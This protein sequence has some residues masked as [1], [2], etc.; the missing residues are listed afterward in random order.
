MSDVVLTEREGGLATVTVNRPE[1]LNALN[2]EVLERLA[3]TFA[4]LA[5]D[6][7]CRVII[8]RGAGDRAF[9]AGADIAAMATLAAEEARTF[10]ELGQ[11]VCNRIESVPQVVIAAVNGYALGGGLRDCAGV[12]L[13]GWQQNRPAL[14]CPRSRSGSSLPGEAP[15]AC[16]AWLGADVRSS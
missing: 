16:P 13:A 6:E 2:Q 12:R 3:S 7:Q 9:I 11:A 8:L 4:E 14:A 1:A 15:N 5:A 10:M